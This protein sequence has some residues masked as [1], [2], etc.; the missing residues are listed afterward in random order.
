MLKKFNKNCKILPQGRNLRNFA[1]RTRIACY[2]GP[3]E[4]FMKK[5]PW[6]IIAGICAMVVFFATVGTIAAFIILNSIAGQTHTEASLFGEWYQIVLFAVDILAA[7]G[8]AGSFAMF[9][10]RQKENL[11]KGGKA[12]G[13]SEEVV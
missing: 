9:V 8:L 1:L 13:K 4:K 3:K 2:A 11:N 7:L 12:G 6:G 10:L 5:L